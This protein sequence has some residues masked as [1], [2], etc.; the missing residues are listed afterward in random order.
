MVTANLIYSE[1][2]K[3]SNYETQYNPSLLFPIPR[4]IKRGEIGIDDKDPGFYGVDIWTHYEISWLNQK[5]KPMVAIGE[6][7]YPASSLNII[8]SKSMKLYFNSFNN[9]KLSGVDE[10]INTVT[11]DLSQ[12]VGS[13]VKFKLIK[14]N[15][16]FNI[17]CGSSAY[18]LD[19]L[20]IEC[21]IYQPAPELLVC[22]KETVNECVYTNLLKSNCLVT[23]Q[24]DWGTIYIDYFGAKI[25]H[26]GL[27]KYIVSLRD[28][29]EF[30]EQCVE[31]VFNDIQNRCNPERL[32]VY[33]RYT[34]RGG[35]D[36]NPYRTTDKDFTVNNLRLVRQ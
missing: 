35:L 32:T 18:C 6:I 25:N 24:P 16:G 12:G 20:D 27:L 9:T 1:L 10:L 31:R 23:N 15:D 28:H 7:S 2:G 19:D 29:N 26:E 11:S 22:E 30:H 17:K 36:I 33:A 13:S 3:K 8:E 34:R 21:S 5:G 4:A 14:L